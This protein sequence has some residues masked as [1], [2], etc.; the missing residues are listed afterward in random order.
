MSMKTSIS[1]AT[2]IALVGVLSAL[3]GCAGPASPAETPLFPR[4]EAALS[5][6]N[7]ALQVRLQLSAS[8]VKVGA[9]V[10]ARITSNTAGFAYLMQLDSEGRNLRLVFPNADDGA[11]FM[12]A[13]YLD[14]PRGT[15]RMQAHGPVGT[16]YLLAVVAPTALDLPALQAQIA[17]GQFALLGSYGAAMVPLR[18]VR[19]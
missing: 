15:W 2:S 13:G 10:T 3:G 7:P 12:G 14:L 16:G 4:M 8:Q 5:R 1:V 9:A 11:N 17:Y 6:A 18:E 19:P